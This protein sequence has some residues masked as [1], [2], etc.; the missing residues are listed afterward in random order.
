MAVEAAWASHSPDRISRGHSGGGEA[1]P[2]GRMGAGGHSWAAA[3]AVVATV[4]RRKARI[5]S[6]AQAAD[7]KVNATQDE[8]DV[9]RRAGLSAGFLRA[10]V[11][12]PEKVPELL[13][14]TQLA[15]SAYK[16]ASTLQ[17][18]NF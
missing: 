4:K 14:P 5:R 1:A 17:K 2:W 16:F 13:L 7:C 6:M 9:A 3:G 10:P 18:G 12:C 11:R 15:T 8:I